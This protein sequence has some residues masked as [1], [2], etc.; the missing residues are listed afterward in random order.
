MT[1]LDLTIT[2]HQEIFEFVKKQ[3][4]KFQKTD[5]RIDEVTATIITRCFSDRSK[6]ISSIVTQ[7][8]EILDVTKA[9][10]E[11]LQICY[12]ESTGGTAQRDKAMQA[13]ADLQ[14]EM[15]A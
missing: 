12:S 15:G 5:A 1:R 3:V 10:H 2:M 14:K 6:L 13:Y 4:R 7:R 9:L 8:S 11:A